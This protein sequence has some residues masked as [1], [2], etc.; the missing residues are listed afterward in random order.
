LNLSTLLFEIIDSVAVITLNRP[1][2]LNAFNQAMLH[3]FIN[4]LDHC[5]ADD[6]IKA[7]V[8]TGAGRAFC[9]GA[10]LSGGENTFKNEFDN[11][12]SYSED[13]NRDSGGIL[14]LRMFNCLKPILVACNGPAVGVG[15]TLQLA[16]DIRIA[17]TAASYSFPFAR[18]GIA[19]DACSS[20]FLPKIV[21]ISK[22][23]E[24]SYSGDKISPDEA[25]NASLISYLTSP[26]DLIAETLSIA[27]KITTNS[28]P[29]SIASTRQMM[30]SLSSYPSP[31]EAHII[32]SKVIQS[33]GSS[34]DAVEG[35]MSFLEKRKATFRNKVSSD[36]PSA[37]PWV[38]S[39]F[40]KED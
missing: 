17:S 22:A 28:S 27:D 36:M 13:F 39:K 16:A 30:W 24:W 2:K 14:T 10:D 23:L 3:D 18:R 1:K 20:W 15:A 26:E 19:P 40:E 21:G 33:R 6:H 11:S 29:V 25:R 38:N 5:D 9:S 12:K 35:V 37:Y 32:D 34:N 8:I 4:A 31:E 7:I